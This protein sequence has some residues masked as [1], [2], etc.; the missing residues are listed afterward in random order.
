M[1]T[2]L[3]A[4]GEGSGS[5]NQLSSLPAAVPALQGLSEM[6]P[7]AIQPL[8]VTQC[9]QESRGCRQGQEI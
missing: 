7:F 8:G 1:E 3:C 9:P 6:F 2:L 4:S 5:S